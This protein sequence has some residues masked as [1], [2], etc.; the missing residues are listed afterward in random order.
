M[1]KAELGKGGDTEGAAKIREARDS[2]QRDERSLWQPANATQSE[3]KRERRY[4]V[5]DVI[6]LIIMYGLETILAG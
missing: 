3:R 6:R 4:T 1:R 2:E 5:C